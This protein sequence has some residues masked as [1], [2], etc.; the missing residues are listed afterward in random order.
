MKS[1]RRQ[2]TVRVLTG[3]F[4]LLVIASAFFCVIMRAQVVREFD[5]VLKARARSL[6]ALT[7]REQ[8]LI[9]IDID[10]DAMPA[11]AAD[12]GAEEDGEPEDERGFDDRKGSGFY[13][14]FRTDG[15]VVKKSS[16]LG[17]A[18]LPCDAV[19]VQA[20]LFR[21]IKLPDGEKGR[22]VQIV[23]TPPVDEP[24]D[25]EKDPASDED[26]AL[27]LPEGTDFEAFRLILVVAGS[28]ERLD[29]LLQL[30]YIT[31]FILTALLLA[32]IGMVVFGAVKQGFRP[33]D[34]LNAQ[35]E[36]IGPDRLEARI[37]TDAPPTE[38]VAIQSAINHLLERV[39]NG[40][41]RERR[42][43][44]N[45]AHELRTP[46]AELRTACEVGER[47][48]DDPAQT[49]RFFGDIKEIALHMEHIAS[50]LLT[51]AR[52]ENGTATVDPV[53]V[54]IADMMEACFRRNQ[55]AMA[56][57]K[58][59]CEI[60][61]DPEQRMTTDKDHFRMIIQ[62]LVDNAVTYSAVGT[63]ITGRVAKTP[64]GTEILI[65]NQVKDIS[66]ADMQHMFE[67]FWQKNPYEGDSGHLGLGLSIAKAIA[68]V[69][70]IDIRVGLKDG[71][72]FEACITL[73]A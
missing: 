60:A 65:E 72:T 12:D 56:A 48:P 49:R 36:C 19:R 13:T 35:I 66:P 50:S 52:C 34:E 73:P 1:I 33:I 70:G 63:T 40:L 41:L 59:T 15:T 54:G 3:T 58:L 27:V 10:E 31:L 64:G 4:L 43:S 45:V 32:G 39:Q 20:P 68:E 23:F 11:Y 37:G 7:S 25:E 61:V 42:F 62:N 9:E 29:A 55:A 18:A 38:L 5:R 71:S 16:S 28:R 53:T 51:L 26:V 14:V 47:W 44:N 24:D 30:T 22:L 69:L 6:I 17:A 2:L 8:N 67:R 21:N 46:V 57:K